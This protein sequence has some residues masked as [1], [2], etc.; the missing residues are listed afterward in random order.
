MCGGFGGWIGFLV[1]IVIIAEVLE[2]WEKAE[3]GDLWSGNSAL[4]F[5]L[6]IPVYP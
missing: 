3:F 1:G 5:K 2:E 6:F 4:L